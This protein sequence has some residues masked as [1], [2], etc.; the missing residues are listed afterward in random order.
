MK[1]LT[2]LAMPSNDGAIGNLRIIEP[3]KVLGEN[4][5]IDP[6]MLNV[7]KPITHEELTEVIKKTDILWFQAVMN[8]NFLWQILNCRRFNPNIKLVLDI[9]DNLYNVNPWN[10]SYTAFTT[11][12]SINAGGVDIKLPKH[13]NLARLRMFETLIME[14]DA[15][16]VT[17][18]LLA[19]TYSHLNNNIF[20]MPNRLIFEKWD[21]PHIPKLKDDKIRISWMGGSSHLMDWLECHAACARIIKKYPNVKIQLQTSPDCYSDFI[22]DL[23]K[24]NIEL[25]DWIDY[26]GHSFRMNC[27]KPDIG[28]I[29]LHEDEFS[30]CKSDLKFSEY[31]TLGVP[32]VCSNIPPYSKVVEHGVTGFL[33]NDDIEFE[34]YL[35]ML[36][37]DS[38]LRDNIGTNAYEWAKKE[39]CLEDNVESVKSILDNIMELPHWHIMPKVETKEAVPV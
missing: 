5:F 26:T 36:I 30:V 22:R 2:V 1:K 18:D 27:I 35:E 19:A 9:D 20:I 16:V 8:Q 3:C 24:E 34:K 21:F 31:A 28:I 11:D 29:P 6:I 33:A 14:A 10:P 25:H 23:G 17:T 39:R 32:C 4:G 15:I 13:R 37:N 7:N 38:A 12:S